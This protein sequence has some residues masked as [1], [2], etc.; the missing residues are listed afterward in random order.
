MS[1]SKLQKEREARIQRLEELG[2]PRVVI[3]NFKMRYY[4]K[5]NRAKYYAVLRLRGEKKGHTIF[6]EDELTAMKNR[7]E[8][9]MN[10]VADG[11]VMILYVNCESFPLDSR[12]YVKHDGVVYQA[13]SRQYRKEWK[14]W[15]KNNNLSKQ[16]A[17]RKDNPGKHFVEDPKRS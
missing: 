16:F 4:T 8:R 12:Y 14:K 7:I 5:N 15:H 2:A 1:K 3:E 9:Y 6:E 11:T 13:R 17:W 10:F